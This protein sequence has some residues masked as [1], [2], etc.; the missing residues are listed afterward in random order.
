MQAPAPNTPEYDVLVKAMYADLVT[1]HDKWAAVAASSDK[2]VAP[3]ATPFRAS[4]S[5]MND[6]VTQWDERIARMVELKMDTG[7][8]YRYPGEYV[9]LTAAE[10]AAGYKLPADT[11]LLPLDTTVFPVP[12]DTSTR[13]KIFLNMSLMKEMHASGKDWTAIANANN[14]VLTCVYTT[15]IMIMNKWWNVKQDSHSNPSGAGR[16][17][18]WRGTSTDQVAAILARWDTEHRAAA[19]ETRWKGRADTRRRNEAQEQEIADLVHKG[20]KKADAGV[21]RSPVSPRKGKQVQ[22]NDCELPNRVLPCLP[23]AVPMTPNSDSVNQMMDAGCADDS[24]VGFG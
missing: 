22:P 5:W 6:T 21:G 8:L 23:H 20:S 24:E 14:L 4:L 1:A 15:S 18:V 3:E 17:K 12:R 19:E 7:M 13:G 16:S 2:T 10:M 11:E 9:T